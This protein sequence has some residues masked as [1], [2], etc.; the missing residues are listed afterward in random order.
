MGTH[1]HGARRSAVSAGQSAHVRVPLMRAEGRPSDRGGRR[2]RPAADRGV[3]GRRPASFVSLRLLRGLARRACGGAVVQAGGLGGL[4]RRGH[5]P[6][7]PETASPRSAPRSWP[8][9]GLR[10]L[11]MRAG[12]PA[13]DS[14]ALSLA[15]AVPG[16][17]APSRPRREPVEALT[18]R[19]ASDDRARWQSR[20]CGRRRERAAPRGVASQG[21]SRTRPARRQQTIGATGGWRDRRR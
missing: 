13:V 1:D 3:D 8:S 20:E 4:V 6:A 5:R 19:A 17:A 12:P 15:H 7:R 9:V 14:T 11:M 16:R 18:S 21:Q 2:G 10:R